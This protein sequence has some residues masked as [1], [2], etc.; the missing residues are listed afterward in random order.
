VKVTIQKIDDEE[1]FLFP[2]GLLDTLGLKIGDRLKLEAEAGAMRF[3]K[4]DE[5][6]ERQLEAAQHA[7]EKYKVALAKLA[8]DD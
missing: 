8:E 4:I 2:E 7:M 3:T 1:G 6:L 5:D